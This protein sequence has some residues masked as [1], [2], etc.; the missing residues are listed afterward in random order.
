[1]DS[2]PKEETPNIELL[3]DEKKLFDVD[4]DVGTSI[5]ADLL[6]PSEDEEE[7]VKSNNVWKHA[8]DI[9]FILSPLHPDGKTLR[10]WVKHQNMDHMG[11]FYQWDTSYF[12]NS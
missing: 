7:E 8:I 6:V 11:Q 1:M 12:E 9:L 3:T 5:F 2:S 4:D 10:Q